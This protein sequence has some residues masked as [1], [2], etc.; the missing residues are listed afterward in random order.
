MIDYSLALCY[1]IIISN[2]KI[3]EIME[4]LTDEEYDE[5]IDNYARCINSWTG[6]DFFV[7]IINDLESAQT[8]FVYYVSD[9]SAPT[10]KNEDLINFTK[11]C[12]EHN[13]WKFINWKPKL[14]LINFCY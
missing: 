2:D 5:M 7:G 1:G 9:L 13:L 4:A 14:M 11:F 3:K 8:D 10:D 12:N 6:D